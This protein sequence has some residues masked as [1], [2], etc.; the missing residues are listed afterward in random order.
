MMVRSAA[1]VAWLTAPAQVAAV[2]L[3]AV[4]DSHTDEERL[5]KNPIRKVVNLL[6][7]M[8][9]KVAEE[10]EKEKDLYEKFVCYCKTGGHDLEESIATNNAKVPAL[11]SDIEASESGIAKLQEDLKSHTADRTTAEAAMSEATAIR[12][13][14]HKKFLEESTELKG[15]VDALG[16]AIPAINSGMSGGAKLLQMTSAAAA[17]LRR[18]AASDSDITEDDRMAVVNF[19]TTGATE[20]AGYSPASGEILGILKEMEADFAKDLAGVESAE[21]EAVKIYDDLIAAK[22]K[23]VHALGLSIE[24][25]TARIGE[26]QVEIVHMKQDLSASEASLI[27]DQ[28]FLKDMEKNCADKEEEWNE[29][30]RVRA[31]ELTAIH[32]TIQILNDDDALDLF[33]KTLPSASFVQVDGGRDKKRQSALAFV[34][35]ARA[36]P[37]NADRPEIKFLAMALQG[38]K[39]DF[40]KV[41]KMIDDMIMLLKQ[42]QVDDD[43]KKEYCSEQLH[44]TADQAKELDQKVEDLG[45]A[46]EDKTENIAQLQDEIKVLNAE[47]TELDKLVQEATEQRKSENAEYTQAMSENT[48]AKELLEYAKNRLMKFYNPALYKPPP[49]A[50]EDNTAELQE[51]AS[52]LQQRAKGAHKQADDPGAP[53]PTFEGSYDKKGEE[54]GGVVNMID[55]LVRDLTKEMTVA[56]K[57]EEHAQKDYEGFMTDSA[58]KRAKSLK[59]IAIK[60]SSKADDEEVKT[61]EEGDL[62]VAN[63]QLQATKIYEMQLH[64]ECD[65]MVQN[66]ELR[67]TARSDEA[68]NLKAAKATLSG[69]DFSLAQAHHG[70]ALRGSAPAQSH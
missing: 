11:Q 4:R 48:E 64:S 28:K 69:A 62:T 25:K 55:L 7:N 1:M 10:G 20:G 68:D 17:M 32:E 21:A 47:I 8:A 40:S 65:W 61:A 15:Y 26:M 24:K 5:S 57:D 12:E 46:I 66:Y 14:E 39:V 2:Q 43:A 45:T 38:K 31:E 37:G 13:K 63:E 51:D 29:R 42:E 30:Q 9:K 60:E 50:E 33:K 27:E 56:E 53:P 35:K 41:I 16:K 58:D 23:E 70:T 3:A 36:K 34:Q 59:A 44:K 52:L 49:T 19:L 67:K 18:A 6:E 22:T 54:S